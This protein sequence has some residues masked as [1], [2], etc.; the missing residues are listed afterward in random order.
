MIGIAIP[1]LF[2]GNFVNG[3][4]TLS[5]VIPMIVGICAEQQ[6]SVSKFI[7]PACVLAHIWPGFL[8]TGGNAAMYLQNNAILE[9]LGG[10][11]TW[12][13]FTAMINKIPIE[14]IVIPFLLF[15]AMKMAPD[16][17]NIPTKQAGAAADAQVADNKAKASSTSLSPS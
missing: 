11:G 9:N 4:A 17:G 1:I 16:L 10:E 3:V 6:R 7:Y 2:L 8:P 15:V 5:I 12:G 14:I 13:F